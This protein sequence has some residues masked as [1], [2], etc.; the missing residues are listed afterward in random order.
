MIEHKIGNTTDYF[1]TPCP[2]SQRYYIRQIN[3]ALE[4]AFRENPE[5]VN[6]VSREHALFIIAEIEEWYNPFAYTDLKSNLFNHLWAT[7]MNEVRQLLL[8]KCKTSKKRFLKGRYYDPGALKSEIKKIPVY[9]K[10]LAYQADIGF[11][12][13]LNILKA[14]GTYETRKVTPTVRKL[15]VFLQSMGCNLESVCY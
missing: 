14:H 2:H 7:A 3:E 4:K 11:G 5:W 15:L 9:Q 6:P 10:D 12:T 1:V 13:L 8:A